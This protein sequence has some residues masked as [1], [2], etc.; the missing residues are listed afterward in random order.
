MEALLISH[1]IFPSMSRVSPG[2]CWSAGKSSYAAWSALA[3]S[4]PGSPLFGSL[5][6]PTNTQ[7]LD[8]A[9]SPAPPSPPSFSHILLEEVKMSD[10]L[11]RERSKPLSLIQVIYW[12]GSMRHFRCIKYIPFMRIKLSA[13]FWDFFCTYPEE[14]FLCR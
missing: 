14:A 8:S 6:S 9:T 1:F 10:N 4:P 3:T 13:L 12:K 5:P 11:M 2:Q 7:G